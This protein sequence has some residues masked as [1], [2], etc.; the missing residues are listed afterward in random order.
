MINKVFSSST[1]KPRLISRPLP[2]ASFNPPTQTIGS[3]SRRCP[4]TW[5]GLKQ[6]SINN[7]Q[8]IRN[9]IQSTTRLCPP[10]QM[11]HTIPNATTPPRPQSRILTPTRR[12]AGHPLLAA[13][14]GATRAGKPVGRVATMGKLPLHHPELLDL[15]LLARHPHRHRTL[16]LLD[17]PDRPDLDLQARHLHQR[18]TV[19]VKV[20]S[21]AAEVRPTVRTAGRISSR[22]TPPPLRGS[23]VRVPTAREQVKEAA[24]AS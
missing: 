2:R 1:C 22:P 23:L 9:P 4:T 19:A 8:T 7:G 24:R 16:E 18:R 3:P 11:A 10:T 14:V 20:P 13:K 5:A 6:P 21:R 12:T 17:R 15:D